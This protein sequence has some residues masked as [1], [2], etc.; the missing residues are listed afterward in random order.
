MTRKATARTKVLVMWEICSK[1]RNLYHNLKERIALTSKLQ[2]SKMNWFWCFDGTNTQK[3]KEEN[4]FGLYSLM[5]RQLHKQ[6]V[7]LTNG[8][9]SSENSFRGIL[10]SEHMLSLEEETPV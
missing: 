3:H 5:A 6:P 2:V 8:I 9:G 4:I 1:A 7:M 10:G